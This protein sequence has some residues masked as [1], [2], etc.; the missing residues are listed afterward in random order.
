MAWPPRRAALRRARSETEKS[1]R[2][3]PPMLIRVIAAGDLPLLVIA[4]DLVML[5]L[6]GTAGKDR[7]GG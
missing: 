2:L 4:T 7:A 6:I 5:V 1:C 3:G